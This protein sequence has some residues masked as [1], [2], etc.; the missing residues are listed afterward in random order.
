MREHKCPARGQSS[1]AVP[2]RHRFC[3]MK[4]ARPCAALLLLV[5]G[6]GVMQAAPPNQVGDSFLS[7]EFG[8]QG[9][10]EQ[11]FYLA[12]DGTCELLTSGNLTS[13]FTSY[14]PSKTGTYSYAPVPGNPSQAA[15]TL[16]LSDGTN[17]SDTLVFTSDTTGH[18]ASLAGSSRF[19]LWLALPNTFLTN[20]SNRVTLCSGDSAI[21]GFV[22]QGSAIRMARA[23]PR[24]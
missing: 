24:A 20:V 22:I 23:T 21:S 5:L 2:R 15:L 1:T 3:F 7:V 8:V 14:S 11:L 18:F 13:T 17:D 19:G 6:V 4:S 10:T 12:A 9:R 16:V